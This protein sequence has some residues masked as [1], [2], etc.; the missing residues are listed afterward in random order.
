MNNRT[1]RLRKIKYFFWLRFVGRIFVVLGIASIVMLKP[2]EVD[3]LRGMNFFQHVSLF[4]ILWILWAW[5][6][7]EKLIPIPAINPR[8]S[9]KYMRR[10]FVPTPAYSKWLEE[11]KPK[12]G[13]YYDLFHSNIKKYSCRALFVAIIWLI[14]AIVLWLLRRYNIIL[15]KYLLLLSGIFYLCDMVCILIWCPFR[16]LFIRNSCCTQCRI[17]NWDTVMLIV[18]VAI[19]PGFFSRSLLALALVSFLTW[20]ITHLLHPERFYPCSNACLSCE[21]CLG[22]AGCIKKV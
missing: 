17:Y 11:G 16:K 12:S 8:G 18:P 4:H 3:M 22:E 21:N 1:N 7:I 10:Y 13:A 9:A 6:M 19:V 20:E 15:D 5:Y 14:F 2:E